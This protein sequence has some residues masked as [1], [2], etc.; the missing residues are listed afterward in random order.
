VFR[1]AEEATGGTARSRS[2]TA[3]EVDMRAVRQQRTITTTR[4]EYLDWGSNVT[5]RQH[6]RC[7]LPALHDMLSSST[8]RSSSGNSPCHPAVV[9]CDAL[10]LFFIAAVV[11]CGDEAR[12]NIPVSQAACR[13]AQHSSE[14][15]GVDLSGELWTLHGW[16][17]ERIACGRA[18]PHHRQPSCLQ[19]STA[20]SSEQ[21]A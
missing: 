18:S 20:H 7:G 15:A 13:T 14:Q 11:V 1:E 9:A 21:A 4:P 16:A 19:D 12:L 6:D 17:V 5:T 3:I 10:C 2:Q 8:S